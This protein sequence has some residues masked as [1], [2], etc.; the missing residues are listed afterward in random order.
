MKFYIKFTH[1]INFI[2][3]SYF[4]VCKFNVKEAALRDRFDEPG[5]QHTIIEM[6]SS[7]KTAITLSKLIHMYRT[8]TE[9]LLS[10]DSEICIVEF[11][12]LSYRTRDDTQPIQ[13]WLSVR[14]SA[15]SF[16]ILDG[17][18]MAHTALRRSSEHL[19]LMLVSCKQKKHSVIV[20]RTP[21]RLSIKKARF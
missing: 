1:D 11:C 20:Q 16:V 9:Y 6:T 2:S 13:A 4:I 17:W 3:L 21:N 19:L 10:W 7:A 8:K 14:P 18:T 5:K 12:I 15:G